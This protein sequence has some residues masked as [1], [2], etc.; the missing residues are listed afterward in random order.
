[1]AK[2]LSNYNIFTED[3]NRVEAY[4][5]PRDL[6]ECPKLVSTKSRNA[7]GQPQAKVSIQCGVEACTAARDLSERF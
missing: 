1:M 6:L 2:P 7:S 4:A 3:S 5:A